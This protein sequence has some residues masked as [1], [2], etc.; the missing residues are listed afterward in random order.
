LKN[1]HAIT[2]NQR[3]PEGAS[4]SELRASEAQRKEKENKRD[5]KEKIKQRQVSHSAGVGKNR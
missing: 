5:E 3:K 2:N 4:A 1:E